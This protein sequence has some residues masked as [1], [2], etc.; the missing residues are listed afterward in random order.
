[1]ARP[2]DSGAKLRISLISGGSCGTANGYVEWFD[3]SSFDAVVAIL[4]FLEEGLKK[5]SSVRLD[6]LAVIV[7]IRWC[8][9]DNESERQ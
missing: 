4:S 3:A 9:E 7:V 6:M 1:M 8:G 2:S 5:V